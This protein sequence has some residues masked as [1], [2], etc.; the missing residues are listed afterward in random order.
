MAA[1]SG[2]EL[3]I[4]SI[5]LS[6]ISSQLTSINSPL[7]S[8]PAMVGWYRF[9]NNKIKFQN[10]FSTLAVRVAAD[11]LIFAPGESTSEIIKKNSD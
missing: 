5:K 6:I 4:L 8:G 11:Q 7:Y 10:P 9:L 1:S 2:K 3:V